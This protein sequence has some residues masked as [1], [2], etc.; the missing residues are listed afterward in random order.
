MKITYNGLIL[1]DTYRTKGL[2]KKLVELLRSKGIKDNAVLQA[3]EKIP[4]HFFIDSAF[5]EFAYLDQPFPIGEGQTISQPYT[6]AFQTQLLEVKPRMKVLE[7]GTGSGYQA[8]VLHEIGAKVFTVERIHKLYIKAKSLLAAMGYDTIRC[9]YGD[10]T[11][12]LPSFAPFDRI[13]VT[14]AAPIIPQTLIDQL[15]VGGILVIPVNSSSQLQV[16][17][18]II[19]TANDKIEIEDH[20]FF[21]FVPLLDNKQ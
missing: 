6:V 10:G 12:G 14:A 18:K 21:R 13:L 20:G 9:F 4:R 2:R 11:K 3:I 7:I 1:E 15:I 19:K 16:M 8:A 17:K 5:L